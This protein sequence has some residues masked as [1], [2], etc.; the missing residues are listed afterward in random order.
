MGAF[1]FLKIGN[2]EN[3]TNTASEPKK[4]EFASDTSKKDMRVTALE[5]GRLQIEFYDPNI[6][7]GQFYNTARLI[8]NSNGYAM[9]DSTVN[10]CMIY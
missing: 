7:F 4:A 9:G 3:N 8:V 5:D 2:K 6:E 1:D 10:D